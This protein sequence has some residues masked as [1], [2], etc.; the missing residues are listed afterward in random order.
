MSKYQHKT[1]SANSRGII[2]SFHDTKKHKFVNY[3]N[4]YVENVQVYGKQPYNTPLFNKVQQKLY[5]EVVYGLNVYT[6]TQIQ[7]MP[8]HQKKTI[9][10][11]YTIAQR[12]INKFKQR[13]FQNLVDKF[14]LNLFPRSPIL[15]AFSEIDAYDPKEIDRHTFKELGIT[16]K[17]VADKLLEKGLLPRDFYQLA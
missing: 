7:Q 6:N 11:R 16:Q 12:V 14:F 10:R 9:I 1:V 3:S 15:K 17:D 8:E 5:G 4:E 13:V 2:V